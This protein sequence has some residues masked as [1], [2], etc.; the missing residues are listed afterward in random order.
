MPVKKTVKSPAKPKASKPAANKSAAPTQ[1]EISQLAE[2]YW[3]ERGRPEG[4]PEMD[5]S[6]AERE[7]SSSQA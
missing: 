4:T 5:W 6:R 7:L 1:Q 2:R 3:M